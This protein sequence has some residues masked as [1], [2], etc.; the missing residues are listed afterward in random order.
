MKAEKGQEQ[1]AEWKGKEV[2]ETHVPVGSVI[3]N[4]DCSQQEDSGYLPAEASR[5][6]QVGTQAAQG[7][8]VIEC[9]CEI[10]KREGT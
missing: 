4:E 2:K 7:M 5:S 3:W 6:P 1:V 8:Q 10:R 9:R